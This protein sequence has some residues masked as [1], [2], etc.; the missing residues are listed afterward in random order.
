MPQELAQLLAVFGLSRVRRLDGAGVQEIAVNL[1]IQV[2]TVGHHHKGEVACDLAENLA[3]IKHHRKALARA[4]RVPKHPQLAALASGLV[5]ALFKLRQCMV[6]THKLVVLRN[7]L[8]RLAVEQHKVFHIVQQTAALK[9]TLH[10]P[11]QAGARVGNALAVDLLLLVVHPQPAKEVLPLPGQAAQTG[12]HRV[13][14]HTK[15]IGDEKLRN[16]V[17]VVGQVVAIGR[18][19]LDVGILQLHKHQRNAVDIQQHIRPP[20]VCKRSRTCA[21]DP[22][23]RHRQKRIGGGTLWPKVDE[24][25]ALVLFLAL[26]IVK[27]H[28][29]AVAHQVIHLTVGR[30]QAHGLPAVGQLGQRSI[31]HRLRNVRVQQQ[32][33]RP[34]PQWQ[35]NI[36]FVL[37]VRPIVQ[38]RRVCRVALQH[39]KTTHM[40]QTLQQRLFD[41]VF[42]NEVG[43]ATDDKTQKSPPKRALMALNTLL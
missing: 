14:Q 10:Q 23:L 27:H 20:V 16:I 12:F 30:N 35:Q 42:G 19:E 26:G 32:G 40:L 25:Q 3:H 29:Y 28:W 24:P 11:L 15:R 9:Q 7:D 22:Q 33:C 4:L 18:L 1:P 37:A 21:F 8:V 34:E 31:Y 41:L 2:V 36:T 6:H 13:G 17:F 39:I 38:I 43:H 5:V